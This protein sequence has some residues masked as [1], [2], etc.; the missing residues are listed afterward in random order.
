MELTYSQLYK[1]NGYQCQI[2]P[3]NKYVANTVDT[4]V[5]IRDHSQDMVVMHVYETNHVIDWMSWSP[6]AQYIVTMNKEHCIANI[7]SISDTNWKTTLSDRRF[8]MQRGW[9]S[10]DGSSILISSDL[11]LKITI[12][13]FLKNKI[14]YIE[15][16]KSIDQVCVPSHDGKYMAIVEKKDGKDYIDILDATSYELLQQFLTETTDVASIQWSP[17][18]QFIIAYDNCLYYKLLVYRFDGYL[19]YSYSAYEHGLGIKCISWH[20]ELLAIG[21]YDEKVRLINT[22]SWQLVTVL[23]HSN[24]I[25]PNSQSS[26]MIYEEYDLPSTKAPTLDTKV[27]YRVLARRPIQL[28]VLRPEFNRH[29]PNIGISFCQFCVDGSLLATKDDTMPNTLWIWDIRQLQVCLIISQKNPLR[30]VVWNP[31]YPH[32][33]AM[34]CGDENVYILYQESSTHSTLS[35]SLKIIPISVPTSKFSVRHIEWSSDGRTLL[36]LDHHLY[37]LASFYYLHCQ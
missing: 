29:D 17:D 18:S 21:S 19:T 35:T 20:D 25:K 4:T 9:W 32:V 37:C 6:N 27:A 1:H 15:H 2:S 30:Q 14:K 31:K 33:L 34:A 13:M 16:P 26:L 12:W 23:S 7:W 11:D 36:L 28:P 8:G 22:C 3:D 10:P 24:V 5:V